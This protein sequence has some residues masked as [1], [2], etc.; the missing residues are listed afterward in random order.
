MPRFSRAELEEALK[1]YNTVHECASQTGDWNPWADL[2][3][4]DAVYKE[5]AYGEFHGR[6]EI[7]KWIVDV[8]AP[9]P[10]MWFPQDW[11]AFDEENGAIVLCVQN[12]WLHPTDPKNRE[13]GFPNWTRLL[14]AG[15]G[16]FSGE[17]DNLQSF[18]GCP[19]RDSGLAGGRR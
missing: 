16:K 7:R 8:M 2:F 4:E 13:F 10:K 11:V 14:Y 9:Y 6:E 3:T 18:S 15:N 17:E 5:H 19:A 1:L 12:V